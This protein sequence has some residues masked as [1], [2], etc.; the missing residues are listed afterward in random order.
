MVMVRRHSRVDFKKLGE[1]SLRN[2]I[3][4]NPST[5]VLVLK[6]VFRK[7]TKLSERDYKRSLKSGFEAK[8]TFFNHYI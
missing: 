7:R 8:L 3:F 4:V 6:I 1:D 2:K 5:E